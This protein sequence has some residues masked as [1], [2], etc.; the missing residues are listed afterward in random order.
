[1]FMAQKCQPTIRSYLNGLN[2][3][4]VYAK[5]FQL[6]VFLNVTVGD[7]VAEKIRENKHQAVGGGPSQPR[8]ET[9][10]GRGRDGLGPLRVQRVTNM[11]CCDVRSTAVKNWRDGAEETRRVWRWGQ[12]F[13][14]LPRACC[15]FH[16]HLVVTSYSCMSLI[17]G[18]QSAKQ[19]ALDV[20]I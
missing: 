10:S 8:I 18:L 12:S 11:A 17:V 1:M 5:K 6:Q 20:D 2:S 13:P 9:A 14:E 15:F 4:T 16:C 19:I 7:S 3:S